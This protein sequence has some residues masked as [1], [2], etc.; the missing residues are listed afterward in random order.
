MLEQELLDYVCK[1]TSAVNVAIDFDTL[2]FSEGI[3]D[4]MSAV[5]ITALVERRTGVHFATADI[6]LDN[7]DSIRRI[8]RFVQSKSEGRQ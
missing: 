2:L 1:R 8:L 5:E 4:S 7:L 3:L 6:N